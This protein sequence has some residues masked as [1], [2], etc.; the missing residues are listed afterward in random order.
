M[1]R[2]SKGTQTKVN[3]RIALI[4]VRPERWII[5]QNS[6]NSPYKMATLKFL[7]LLQRS[8]KIHTDKLKL[9]ALSASV[10][11]KSGDGIK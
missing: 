8:V 10:M 4:L 9:K 7:P 6:G 2:D 11:A 3:E 1:G 5:P